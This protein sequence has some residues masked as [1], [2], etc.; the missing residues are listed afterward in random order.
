MK[1]KVKKTKVRVIDKRELLS[2]QIEIRDKKIARLEAANLEMQRLCSAR[3]E[4]IKRLASKVENYR[5]A[6]KVAAFNLQKM[7]HVERD[8]E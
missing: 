6:M 7:L 2:I 4:N 1:K 8:R 5:I 3:E